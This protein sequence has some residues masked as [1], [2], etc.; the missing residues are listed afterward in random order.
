MCGLYVRAAWTRVVELICINMESTLHF[1]Y[2]SAV[3]MKFDLMMCWCVRMVNW[4]L[5][6]RRL[7]LG[8]AVIWRN[9]FLSLR[10]ERRSWTFVWSLVAR[11]C[12]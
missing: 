8:E 10:K 6:A 2:E 9:A 4:F 3:E 1:M 12:L 5:H 11:Q 7:S